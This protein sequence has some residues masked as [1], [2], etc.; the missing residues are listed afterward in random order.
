MRRVTIYI[1]LLWS[2]TVLAQSAM[3]KFLA[4]PYIKYANVSVAVCR[5]SNGVKIDEY[6]SGNLIAPASTMKLFTTATALELLGSNYRYPTY[7]QYSGKI[8]DGVLQGNLYIVGHGDP[9]LG[10]KDWGGSAFLSQW[11]N[12]VQ[13]AGIKRIDGKVIGD[14]S[15]YDGDA[16]NPGWIYED[17][18]NYYAPGI[19]A[20]SYLDNTMNIQL[21]SGAVG[22]VAQVIRTFPTIPGLNFENH[23]RCT[24]IDYD[25]A[26][27]HGLPYQNCRYLTGC[28]PSNLGVFGVRG[29]I[30]NPSLLLAQHLSAQLRVAGIAVRDSAGYLSESDGKTKTLLYTHY[31][32]PLSDIVEQTNLH[33]VNLN[34]EMMFRNLGAQSKVPCTIQHASEY[35]QQFWLNRGV[36]LVMARILDGCGLAPQNGLSADNFVQLLCYMAHSKEHAAF[37]RSLPVSGKTGTLKT[38]LAKTELEGKVH[39]KSGTIKGTRNYAGYMDMPNGDQLVFAVLVSSSN[40]TGQQ[41]KHAIEQYLLDVYRRNK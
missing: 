17:I 38:L 30:P 26:Y 13:Q 37:V 40:G 35:M 29:D 7:L 19:F 33:S 9:T 21:K 12:A 6:R 16:L 1:L 3:D 34:A 11:V 32:A 10:G 25:G 22:S 31:S 15:Y 27:V 5:L 2:S 36:D 28:I 4:S 8:K 24:A 23:I 20:L 18:G 41:I 14:G 39:A